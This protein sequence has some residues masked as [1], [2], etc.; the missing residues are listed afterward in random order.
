MK[1]RAIVCDMDGTLLK[2]TGGTDHIG[3]RT[4]QALLE[5]QAQ[6][7]RLILASGRPHGRLMRYA[8]ELHMP[9][10]GGWLIEVNGTALYDL[11]SGRREVLA[12]LH[13]A[14]IREL[15]AQ[16]VQMECEVSAYQDRGLW[17]HIP[18]R[19]IAPKLAYRQA[20]GLSEDCPL[21]A[22][23]FAL[24]S[25]NRSGYPD[26]HEANGWEDLPEQ[27]NKL[28]VA[29]SE[30]R[31]A[32]VMAM[33]EERFSGRFWW[34]RTSANWL[35]IMPAHVNK[36]EGLK[37]AASRMGIDPS[38]IMAFGDGENDIGMLSLC[39]YGYAMGNALDSVK[40]VAYDV[41]VSNEEEGVARTV[42]RWLRG[43]EC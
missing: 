33:L 17:Y 6:G 11:E 26:Q 13:R 23:A 9:Q 12:Q 20:H 16:L 36:A 27:M 5:A 30:A 24:V 15:Y 21:T 42:E 43:K 8:Q 4:R 38:Q 7:I 18:K 35:E 37:Q 41:C 14:E 1:I 31:I 39:G 28:C 40:K 29:D 2:R 3:E 22:G 10:H 25:D 19:L 32:S 34:G